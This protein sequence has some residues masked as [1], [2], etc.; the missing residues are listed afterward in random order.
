MIL[1]Y[2]HSADKPGVTGDIGDVLTDL[3][4]TVILIAGDTSHLS[5]APKPVCKCRH[6]ALNQGISSLEHAEKKRTANAAIESVVRL[7]HTISVNRDCAQEASQFLVK[8]V[9]NSSL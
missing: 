6:R 3:L 4:I 1:C 2:P 9:L 8:K 5:L 7:H